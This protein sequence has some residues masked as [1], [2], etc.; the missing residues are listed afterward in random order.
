MSEQPIVVPISRT[1]M[2]LVLA[3]ALLFVAAGVWMLRAPRTP[4]DV[5]AAWF[6]IV[7][8]GGCAIYAGLRLIRSTPALVIDAN[9]IYDNASALGAGFISWEDIAEMR[10]YTMRNQTFLGIMPK[11]L[12][13]FLARQPAWKRL[14]IQFNLMTGGPAASIPQVI[15]PMPVVDLLRTIERRYKRRAGE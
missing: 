13:A 7:F 2:A 8:F 12:D 5:P 1:K 3:G 4:I 11:D 6:A 15:L 14:A 9:G 10:P